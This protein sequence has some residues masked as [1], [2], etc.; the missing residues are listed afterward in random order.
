V[1]STRTRDTDLLCLAA[2]YESWPI[3]I[4]VLLVVPLGVIG[5]IVATSTRGL[6]NDV[7]F[8]VGLLTTVG[9]AVKNVILIVEFARRSSMPARLSWNPRSRRRRNGCGRS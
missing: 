2:L 1:Q 3:P 5:A 6:D 7:Y 8:Q 4:W 9:L